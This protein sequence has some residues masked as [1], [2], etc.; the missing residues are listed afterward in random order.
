[1]TMHLHTN[2]GGLLQAFALKSVLEGLGHEVEILDMRKKIW[3]PSPLKAPL[4]YAKRALL[5]LLKKN[6]PEVFREYRLKREYPYISSQ[7]MPFVSNE[8]SP[9]LIERYE[10][11]KEGEYDAFVVGSDQVWRP[12][13]FE[14]TREAFLSFTAGWNVVRVSYAASFGTAEL[15]YEYQLLE[16][17]SRLLAEFDG[18]SVREDSG[19]AMCDEWLDCDRAVHVLD[20]VMLLDA[21][22][23]RSMAL[24]A[25]EHPAKGRLATYILDRTQSKSLL[26]ARMSELIGKNVH[27]LSV[28][29]KDASIPLSERVVPPIENWIAGFADSDFVVTDSFHGCVMSI[30]MHKPFV[31]VG[32]R[33]RGLARIDSLLSMFG[34]ESR[35]IGGLDPEDDGTSW[36]MEIDWKKVDHVLEEQRRLSMGFLCRYLPVETSSD[37]GEIKEK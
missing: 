30:L 31:V 13:C 12:M 3:F 21:D 5:S 25:Q 23:Y 18:V 6:G 28:Y 2:Y 19:V 10:D 34:L 24:K 8:L 33:L 16:D 36:L 17:C 11:V 22:R 4:I 1:V 7:L 29:P 26:V 14:Y 27:D 20:P 15:E 32:N 37:A 35:F 9:R